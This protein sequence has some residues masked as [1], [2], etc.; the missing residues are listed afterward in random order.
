MLL[1]ILSVTVGASLFALKKPQRLDKLMLV[2]Y[3]VNHFKEYYRIVSHGFIHADGTHLFFN[4]FVLW[5]F[6]KT[7]EAEMGAS[8]PVLYF[9]L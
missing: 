1:L 3:N 5:E 9:R 4:M 7:V 8:F 6:G 2:P